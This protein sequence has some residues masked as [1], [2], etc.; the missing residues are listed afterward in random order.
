MGGVHHA[1]SSD[2]SQTLLG[3]YA[4]HRDK[5]SGPKFPHGHGV[6]EGKW[7]PTSKFTHEP[8]GRFSRRTMPPPHRDSWIWVHN[9]GTE[10]DMGWRS[11]N[12]FIN[13]LPPLERFLSPRPVTSNT[14]LPANTSSLMLPLALLG[15]IVI[16]KK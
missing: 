4:A 6:N 16:M 14:P 10:K 15:L 9:P 11:G 5:K 3:Y 13:L 8:R 7:V 12:G 1:Y 2:G